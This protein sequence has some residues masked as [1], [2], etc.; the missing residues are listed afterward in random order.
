MKISK[1][2]AMDVMFP[3]GERSRVI[4]YTP[5]KSVFL[6]EILEE[7]SMIDGNLGVDN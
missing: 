3:E 4:R 6:R 2:D 5:P 1:P 7:L